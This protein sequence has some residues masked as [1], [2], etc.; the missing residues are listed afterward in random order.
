M[1]AYCS[2]LTLITNRKRKQSRCLFYLVRLS[3]DAVKQTH[4]HTAFI[5]DITRIILKRFCSCSL[6]TK[7]DMNAAVNI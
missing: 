2:T 6:C 7:I 4:T 3:Q 1:S 5:L